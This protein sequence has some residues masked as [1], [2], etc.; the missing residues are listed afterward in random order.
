M[1]R[2]FLKMNTVWLQVLSAMERRSGGQGLVQFVRAVNSEE[3]FAVKFFFKS[4]AFD[5]EVAL[6]QDPVLRGMMPATRG[7][8]GN[9][10]RDVC[11]ASGYAWPPCII[12]E[13]GESLQEWRKREN[14]DFITTL[15]V[16][17]HLSIMPTCC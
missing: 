2:I 13:R 12:I 5:A 14:E 1:N 17:A 8:V 7:F 9:D 10:A 11:A 4:A 3:A 6:Y 15:Q 16:Q